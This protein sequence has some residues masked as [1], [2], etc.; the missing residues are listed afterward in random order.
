MAAP[1][2]LFP[3]P[4]SAPEL[5]PYWQGIA[6]HELRL[7]R[8]SV[9]GQ[10]DWYPSASGPACKGG[11]YDWQV[12]GSAATIFTF[13]HVQRPLLPSVAKPYVVGL[14]CPDDA[15]TCRIAAQLDAPGGDIAIGARV[16]LAFSGTAEQSFAYCIVDNAKPKVNP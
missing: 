13:T 1:G 6:K 5:A 2:P 12:V 9:C 10:W 15:P 11:H 7:P 4:R 16:Q 3:P 14:V 8:C